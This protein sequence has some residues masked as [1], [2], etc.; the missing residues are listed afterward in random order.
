MQQKLKTQLSIKETFLHW[1]MICCYGMVVAK[2]SSI[3][4]YKTT[5]SDSEPKNKTNLDFKFLAVNAMS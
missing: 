4:I 2:H 5:W 1:K 3:L